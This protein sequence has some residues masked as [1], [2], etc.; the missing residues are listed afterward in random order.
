MNKFN[1]EIGENCASSTCNCCGK[2]SNTGHG[3][4]YKNGDAYAVYY[5]GWSNSHLKKVVSIAIAIGEWADSATNEMR[6]CFGIEAIDND[7][8]ISLSVISPENSPWPDTGLL[9]KM[10][11]RDE[12]LSSELLSEVFLIIEVA[13]KKH[14]AIVDYL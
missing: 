8:E 10:L 2:E 14:P 5:A 7:N 6:T 3:F 1:I 12:A 11:T 9:G 4:V 13:L